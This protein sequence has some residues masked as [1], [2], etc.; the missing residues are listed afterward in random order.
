MATPPTKVSSLPNEHNQMN[1]HVTIIKP[2]GFDLA[3]R[4]REIYEYRD[5]IF[6]LVKRDFVAQYKQTVLGPAWHVIQPLTTTLVMTVVFGKI[7]RLSTDGAPAFLFYL[8]GATTWTYFSSVVTATSSTFLSNAG[9]FGKV[10]FPR[11]VV[12]LAIVAS[13]LTGLVI[14]TAVFITILVIALIT[15]DSVQPNG[16]ILLAPLLIAMIAALS[17]AMGLI[18]SALTT[19]YRDLV[20]LVGFGTQLLMYLT[21]VIY[22]ISILPPKWQIVA[23]LNPLAPI[24]EGLRFAFLG[25]G[26]FHPIALIVSAVTISCALAVG[27]SLFRRVERNFMDTI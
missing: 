9:L 21:P 20:V 16:Y 15:S 19:R 2:A 8:L 4:M 7:A 24:F 25:T 23:L 1:P 27:L 6:M 12:P 18:V 26:S 3:S 17:L 5:L 14:Q 22:P 13:K 10:Y 11:L